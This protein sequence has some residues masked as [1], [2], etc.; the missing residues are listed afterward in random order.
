MPLNV[1]VGSAA[2][3]GELGWGGAA[4]ELVQNFLEPAGWRVHS[5]SRAPYMQGFVR[6][7]PITGACTAVTSGSD[8]TECHSVWFDPLMTAYEGFARARV[9][10]YA[11]TPSILVSCASRKSRRRR[12]STGRFRGRNLAGRV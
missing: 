1:K 10:V 11:R 2:A 9:W 4:T 12:R 7:T 8:H 6:R 3:D 5:V